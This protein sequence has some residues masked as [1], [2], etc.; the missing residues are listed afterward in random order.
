MRGRPSRDTMVRLKALP[1]GQFLRF[2]AVGTVGFGI[3]A[4]IVHG[5]IAGLGL[6]PYAA[7]VPAYLAAATVTW[8]LNR[9]FTFRGDHAGPAHHQWRRF[10]AVNAVG[11]AVNGGVY[12]ALI[13]TGGSFRTWPVL[14]V[15]L[16]SLAGM[17][18]NFTASRRLVFRMH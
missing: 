18:F 7:R 15:A 3:D 6:D 2:G 10:L 8:A 13:A 4:S 12:A 5:C 17:M 1:V 14:A 11:A 9:R 16:G